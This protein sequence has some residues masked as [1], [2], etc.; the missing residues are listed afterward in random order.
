MI[1]RRLLCHQSAMLIKQVV[2]TRHVLSRF[3]RDD[4]A[5]ALAKS[6]AFDGQSH[7][8]RYRHGTPSKHAPCGHRTLG[9]IEGGTDKAPCPA[10]V[11]PRPWA[12]PAAT[13]LAG[14]VALSRRRGWVRRFGSFPPRLPPPTSPCRTSDEI[15]GGPGSVPAYHGSR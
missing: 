10:P 6:L 1:S 14:A 13:F 5:M 4:M 7:G 8:Q 9:G 12:S 15:C 3:T 2:F 11:H